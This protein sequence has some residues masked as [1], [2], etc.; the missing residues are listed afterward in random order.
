MKKSVIMIIM[1]LSISA[2]LLAGC[3]K[4]QPTGYANYQG[5]GQPAAGVGGGCGVQAPVSDVGVAD[6]IE[7]SYESA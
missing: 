2:L 7:Q 3:T 6:Q 5:A 1:N 4:S